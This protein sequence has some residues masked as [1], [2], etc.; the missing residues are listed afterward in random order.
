M[1]AL[2]F[3]TSHGVSGL[4]MRSLDALLPSRGKR[5]IHLVQSSQAP[6]YI[7][8]TRSSLLTT[9]G[10][11]TFLD[12]SSEHTNVTRWSWMLRYG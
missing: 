5:E 12:P 8:C 1:S 2:S 7:K 11:R 3:L 10:A 9:P 6:T 4:R